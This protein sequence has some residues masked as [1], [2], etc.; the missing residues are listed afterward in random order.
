MTENET[1]LRRATGRTPGSQ[2]Q[3][4]SSLTLLTRTRRSLPPLRIQPG[5][6]RVATPIFLVQDVV[7]VQLLV[8]AVRYRPQ[9]ILWVRE[10]HVR[11]SLPKVNTLLIDE[12]YRNV[13]GGAGV[14][15]SC[16]APLKGP[17]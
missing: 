5:Q 14:D 16:G 8:A 13:P 12:R 17:W 3:V 11:A 15:C 10:T 6:R 7:V 4:K 1:R 9:P 2:P